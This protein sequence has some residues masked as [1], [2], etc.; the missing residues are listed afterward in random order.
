MSPSFIKPT[1][2]GAIALAFEATALGNAVPV[3]SVAGDFAPERYLD[4]SRAVALKHEIRM[5]VRIQWYPG[6]TVSGAL[7]SAHL[8]P[9]S[10]R[11]ILTVHSG[12]NV[13][14]VAY[15]SRP[16][17]KNADTPLAPG[18]GISYWALLW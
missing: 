17:G 5:A 3:V 7:A 12:A 8:L 11:A 9:V 2:G 6:M 16:Y 10:K 13:F 4:V 14:Q 15:Q 18:A 1:L